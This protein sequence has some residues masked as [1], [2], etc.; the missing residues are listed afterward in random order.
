MTN[1]KYEEFKC[2][3]E[4]L[5]NPHSFISK[6]NQEKE[7]EDEDEDEGNEEKGDIH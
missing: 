1:E 4:G 5:V 3:K 6:N 7:N 2:N